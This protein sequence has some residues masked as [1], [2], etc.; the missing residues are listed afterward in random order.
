MHLRVGKLA[1]ISD[2]CV[3]V[4]GKGLAKKKKNEVR[5][6]LGRFFLYDGHYCFPFILC[7]FLVNNCYQ[8]FYSKLKC[9]SQCNN[10]IVYFCAS[11]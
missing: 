6:C 11:F 7:G 9:I 5:L 3:S 10:K 1:L 2:V 4:G 8:S